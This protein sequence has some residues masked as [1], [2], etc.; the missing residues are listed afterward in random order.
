M[1]GVRGHH[2]SVAEVTLVDGLP[3]TTPAETWCGLGTLLELDELI[4]AG[5]GL[6]RRK[7]PLCS[8]EDLF[9]AL[10]RNRGRRGMAATS[11]ALGQVRARSDSPRETKLRL[12]LVRAG[13]PE[14]AVNAVV[15]QTGNR[16]RFGDLVYEE[17]KVIVEYD[18]DHHRTSATQYADDIVRLEEL[19]RAGW[20]IIRVLKEH[21]DNPA[22]IIE[23]VLRALRDHGW[24]G[25]PSKSQLLR[26]N[27]V[28]R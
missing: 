16:L 1:V 9:T 7:S 28:T 2:A 14:P 26:A 15:S 22:D 10:E 19:V 23:R 25:R 12:L 20:T 24:K 8:R 17:W 13:L 5:D 6:L 18:G 11:R 4:A 27:S 21:F 3:V